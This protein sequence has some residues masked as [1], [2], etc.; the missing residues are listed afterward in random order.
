MPRPGLMQSGV[1][2]G[3]ST[4]LSSRESRRQSPCTRKSWK[5]P[6]SSRGTSPPSSWSGIIIRRSRVSGLCLILDEDHLR[7]DAGKAASL[8]LAGGV[9]LFQYRNKRAPRRTI[10]ETSLRLVRLLRG[11]NAVFIVNDHADIAAAVGARRGPP[12]EG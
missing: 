11:K 12:W 1:C 3:P 7:V 2:S 8:A 10:Y 4:N 9:R 5:T 6:I